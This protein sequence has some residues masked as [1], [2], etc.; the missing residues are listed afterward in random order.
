ML[1]KWHKE[2]GSARVVHPR[3]P[4]GSIPTLMESLPNVPAMKIGRSFSRP[5]SG[6]WTFKSRAILR[7]LLI[8]I[9]RGVLKCGV[10]NLKI[11]K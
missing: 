3:D 7:H 11:F 10:L 9:T 8:C 1:V 5:L 6:S 4:S 2:V